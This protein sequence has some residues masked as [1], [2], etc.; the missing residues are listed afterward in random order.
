MD[1]QDGPYVARRVYDYIF[2][3]QELNLD[4]IPYAVDEA[5]RALRDTGVL[6]ARWAAFVHLGG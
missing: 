1:D 6:A 5:T 2:G 4:D 3:N